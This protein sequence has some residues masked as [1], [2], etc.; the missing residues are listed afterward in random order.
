M[1]HLKTYDPAGNIGCSFVILDTPTHTEREGD[2]KLHVSARWQH[3]ASPG[4]NWFK[5]QCDT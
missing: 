1:F 2:D 3:A 5:E 4:Y